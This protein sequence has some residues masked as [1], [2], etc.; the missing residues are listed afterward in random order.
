MVMAIAE[1]TEI[2]RYHVVTVSTDNY[3]QVSVNDFEN[4]IVRYSVSE[5]I[6]I[7][8]RQ[9]EAFRRYLARMKRDMEEGHI[10]ELPHQPPLYLQEPPPQIFQKFEAAFRREDIKL[11]D[12]KIRHSYEDVLFP[13][14]ETGLPFD[15]ELDLYSEVD[16]HMV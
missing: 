14:E 11:K 8:I 1:K 6:N 16:R 2:R 15:A 5:N 4:N 13:K 3:G 10:P 9:V 7:K 12:R